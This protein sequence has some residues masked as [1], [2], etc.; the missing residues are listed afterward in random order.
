[1]DWIAAS[2]VITCIVTDEMTASAL[3]SGDVPVLGTPKVVALAEEAAVA[4]IGDRIGEGST[5][6]G[7]RIAIDHLAPSRVGA[8]VEAL[9]S[10]VDIDGRRVSFDVTVT[11]GA[12]TVAR[13]THERI[14]VDRDRFL[15]S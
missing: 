10:V 2:A 11:E 1:M 7:T 13:G 3:G 12:R 9:A 15:R 4:A 6:V 14:V 5:S 8:T